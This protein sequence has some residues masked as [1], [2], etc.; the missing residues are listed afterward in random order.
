MRSLTSPSTDI[1]KPAQQKKWEE[2]AK[3]LPDNC[4][5]V[6]YD[7]ILLLQHNCHINVQ[8]VT[9]G[10]SVKYLFFYLAQNVELQFYCLCQEDIGEGAKYTKGLGC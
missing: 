10:L 4:D 9:D 3:P 1:L 6:P 8:V 7:P 5:I 2:E